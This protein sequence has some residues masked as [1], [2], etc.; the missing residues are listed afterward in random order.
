M[1]PDVSVRK[2]AGEIWKVGNYVLLGPKFVYKDKTRPR[3]M[4][5][6]IGQITEFMAIEER[7]K[8]KVFKSATDFDVTFANTYNLDNLS[9]STNPARDRNLLES[10]NLH[11]NGRPYSRYSN[12][13]A[14][15]HPYFSTPIV[16]SD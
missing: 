11:S 5:E 4:Y 14:F 10:R 6:H 8:V 3:M 13:P 16:L 15:V 9:L 7:V 12:N 2:V 1:N